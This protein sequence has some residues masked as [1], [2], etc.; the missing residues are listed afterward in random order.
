M[1]LLTEE[2]DLVEKRRAE[3][4][5]EMLRMQIKLS[6]LQTANAKTK[7]ELEKLTATNE[8]LT[9]NN[10]TLDAK[11][12]KLDAEI[13]AL[14]QRIDVNSL[15]KEVD[16]EELKLMVT[17]TENMNMAFMNMMNR[18]ESIRKEES[19]LFYSIKWL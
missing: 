8:S 19:W 12:T 11:N 3:G 6:Q 16:V 7:E 9:K 1:E 14:I 13:V 17:N 18:W 4:R 15:L 2:A 5:E 10:A